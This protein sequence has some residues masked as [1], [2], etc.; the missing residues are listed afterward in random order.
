MQGIDSLF[1]VNY[2]VEHTC[3]QRE[4]QKVQYLVIQRQCSGEVGEAQKGKKDHD[5]T[6]ED[7]KPLRKVGAQACVI[8]NIASMRTGRSR[9]GISYFGMRKR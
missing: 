2:K 5:H 6:C 9:I 1:Y 4:A 8:E 7:Q 3:R